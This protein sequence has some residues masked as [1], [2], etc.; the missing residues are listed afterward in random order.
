MSSETKEKGKVE[1]KLKRSAIRVILLLPYSLIM[2]YFIYIFIQFG[3]NPYVVV[4]LVI[5]VFLTTIGP[6][7]KKKNRKSLYSQ[8]FPD[9]KRRQPQRRRRIERRPII[10][11][12]PTQIQVQ[13]KIF[14][15]VD[16][17]FEFRE[18]LISN[19]ENCGNI[20]PKFVKDKCPFCG[21]QI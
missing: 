4:I 2:I 12:K 1:A 20:F 7:F 10:E 8:M 14:K 13:S 16:I 11:K 9:R 5:F 18:P 19:C 21:E 15:P 3:S 17:E 6:F